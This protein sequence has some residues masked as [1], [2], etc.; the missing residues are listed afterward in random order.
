MASMMV[1]PDCCDKTV[2]I[3]MITVV[4]LVCAPRNILV[5]L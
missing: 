5:G 2:P 4:G 1:A 3:E